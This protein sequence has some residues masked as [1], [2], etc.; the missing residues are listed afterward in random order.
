MIWNKKE[1][2]VS[3]ISL[4][5]RGGAAIEIVLSRKSFKQRLEGDKG[6]I[7][8]IA[9]EERFREREQPLQSIQGN[10]CLTCSRHSK[11]AK[12]TGAERARE[13][14]VGNEDS[15]CKALEVISR[16]LIFILST[17]PL[18]TFEQRSAMI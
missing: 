8:Q 2:R 15:S 3:K 11:Q 1:V 18:E 5:G 13:R 16:T 12:V 6:M 4:I 17:E 7:M 14:A 9:G 10:T